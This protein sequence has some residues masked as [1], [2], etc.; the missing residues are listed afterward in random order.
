MSLNLPAIKKKISNFLSGEEGQIS[1]KAIVSIGTALAG[2]ATATSAA[3]T[4]STNINYAK[5]NVQASHSSSVGTT[6]GGKDCGD[7]GSTTTTSTTTTSPTTTTSCTTTTSGPNC[8]PFCG[9]IV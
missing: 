2:V 1:K 3:H 4:S 7:C 5:P 8:G 9:C 6:S